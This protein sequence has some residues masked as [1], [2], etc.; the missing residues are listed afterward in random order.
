[1]L[2]PNVF[3]ATSQLVSNKARS[4]AHMTPRQ[5]FRT[6]LVNLDG[7]G[8]EVGPS[9]NPIVS[10]A[11][12]HRIETL[13]Y[14]DA[15]GLREK[16]KDDPSVDISRIEPVDFVSDGRP[17]VEIIGKRGC[18]DYILAS[19]VIEHTP[20]ML[21]FLK[22]CEALLK[23]TGILVLAVPDKRRCFD[24]FQPLSSTGQVL[25]AH[26]QGLRRPSIGSIFD[27]HAYRG[28]RNGVIAWL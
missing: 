16:Y 15:A 11:W 2:A 1:M 25:Q 23:P 9:Y 14:V 24:V 3:P 5:L 13:D 6:G 7:I 27:M 17:M 20:D 28:E 21:G 18:Y 19:H 22:D 12:T 4:A 10:K 8:L 26:A